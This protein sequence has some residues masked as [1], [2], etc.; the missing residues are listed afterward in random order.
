MLIL[1][2]FL[3]ALALIIVSTIVPGFV[4]TSFW[5]ALVAALFLGLVNVLIKPVLILLTLPI[6]LLTLGI[7]TLVIN[8]LM[9]ELVASI[10]KGFTVTGFGA[11]F[12]GALV[13]WVVSMGINQIAKPAA[14]R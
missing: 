4:V 3:N 12:I 2:W 1:R 10:V 14:I 9:I 13:L 5:S 8:A 7:F 6:N 11:A